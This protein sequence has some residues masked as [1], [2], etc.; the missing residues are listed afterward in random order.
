MAALILLALTVI[1][2][3]A[4]RFIYKRWWD[5]GL[6][7][8]V[9]FSARA[10][11]ESETLTITETLSN[12]KPLPLPLIEVTLLSRA[13]I[14]AETRT[15]KPAQVFSLFAYRSAEV[16]TRYI[17][18]RRGFFRPRGFA[19]GGFDLTMSDWHTRFVQTREAVTV[20]P[21]PIDAAGV[22]IPY[23]RLAG[24]I[25]ARRFWNDDPFAFRGIRLY[26]PGD[27]LRDINSKASA[28]CGTLMTNMYDGSAVRELY[29][30]LNVQ[31]HM[32]LT[33]TRLLEGAIR[34]AAFLARFFT[35]EGIP[36]ALLSNGLD[37]E[38]GAEVQVR[39][40]TSQAH[41]WR[42]YEALARIDLHRKPRPLA[43]TLETQTLD[44]ER[45]YLLISRYDGPEL[46]AWFDG[47][48]PYG[49]FWCVPYRTGDNKIRVAFDERIAGY[50]VAD[51]DAHVE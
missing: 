38:T 4:Q 28:R 51:D 50:E 49:G 26:H 3:M 20:Y 42:I 37:A 21:R 14:A 22:S 30:V 16:S 15:D 17:C 2:I 46:R 43:E 29:M 27:R 32:E 1:F 23:R 31:D 19:I 39:P 45:V 34:L 35:E 40:G 11:F 7:L 44:T 10:V 8:D 47:A 25:A 24:E 48:R 12:N 13:F 6:T 18:A 9:R 36:T 5:T 33:D 41:L